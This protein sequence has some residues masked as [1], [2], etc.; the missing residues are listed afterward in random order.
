MAGAMAA[1]G[2]GDSAA[3]LTS[4]KQ[5]AFDSVRAIWK[6]RAVAYSAN[7]DE[8]FF[9]LDSASKLNYAMTFQKK[10]VDLTD[11]DFL[12]KASRQRYV[13]QR[14][15]PFQNHRCVVDNPQIFA[16]LLGAELMNVTFEG[17]CAAAAN[18]YR[19]LAS[20]LDIDGKIRDFDAAGQRDAAIALNVGVKSGESNYAF[21][22]FDKALGKIID[23]N[24]GAFDSSIKLAESRLSPLRWIVGLGGALVWL[25]A[26]LGLR[27]RLNEYRA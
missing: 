18:A 1:T 17:E 19:T 8:S 21:D 12:A 11:K 10:I 23:I 20:Y 13:E 14:V 15:T 2:V 24:Q 6:S 7:A 27:P 26:F 25:L 4:A 3:A 22:A 16:G 5:D 9:L